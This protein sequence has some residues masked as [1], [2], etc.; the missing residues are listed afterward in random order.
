MCSN[1]TY[2]CVYF[3]TFSLN[4]CLIYFVYLYKYANSEEGESQIRLVYP[5]FALLRIKSYFII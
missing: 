4:L 5:V 3:D 1:C 2:N